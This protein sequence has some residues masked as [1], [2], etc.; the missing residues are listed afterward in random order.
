MRGVEEAD[1][2]LVGQGFLI[3]AIGEN[4]SH[5]RILA[6][7]GDAH[8][9]LPDA[10]RAAKRAGSHRREPEQLKHQRRR[11]RPRQLRAK[12]REMASGDMAALMRDD[13]DHF[14]RGL[15]AHQRAGVDE[16]IV[17]IDD[18]GV[19]APVVDD[20]DLDR[21][22]AETGSREDRLGVSAHQ[23]FGLG[24]AD[25]ARGVGRGGADQYGRKS[26][27]QRS[28]KS[29]RRSILKGLTRSRHG[30]PIVKVVRGSGKATES[31]PSGG[32]YVRLAS[33]SSH[34]LIGVGMRRQRDREA[35]AALQL[36]ARG[37]GKQAARAPLINVLAPPPAL[38]WQG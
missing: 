11:L 24:V 21:L 38:A 18:E 17:P 32:A 15:S 12:P 34:R 26:S 5:G 23:G 19:E 25:H 7:V 14:V 27:D 9:G 13:A 8:A 6:A 4:A 20:V 1:A 16:H 29:P 2:G 10:W 33:R 28:T 36:G 30:R 37:E 35:E 3:L 31:A 22:R